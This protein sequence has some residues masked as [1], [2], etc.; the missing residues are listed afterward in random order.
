[1]S[2]SSINHTKKLSAHFEDTSVGQTTL[3]STTGPIAKNYSPSKMVA[4]QQLNSEFPEVIEEEA[5]LNG[6][7]SVQFNEAIYKDG[8]KNS[9]IVPQATLIGPMNEQ[10]VVEFE[11]ALMSLN[12]IPSY[13]NPCLKKT[14]A[15][16]PKKF[17]GTIPNQ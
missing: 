4:S 12:K 15:L 16:G 14:M 17:V 13:P 9:L 3:N 2:I 5:S 10:S 1:M 11:H 8:P 7:P 6:G